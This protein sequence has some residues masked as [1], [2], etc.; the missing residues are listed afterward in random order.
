MILVNGEKFNA[1]E[2]HNGEV[3][4]K[5]PQKVNIDSNV[6]E[7]IFENNKDITA[8]MFAKEYLDD[9]V[10]GAQRKLIMKYCPYERMD[11]AINDQMF[12]MK[13]FARIIAKMG[14]DEVFILDPHS[15]VCVNELYK[16]GLNVR[17]INLEEYVNKVIDD[18]QPDYICYPDKGAYKKY[19]KVLK[20]IDIPCFYGQKTRDLENKGHITSYEL[21]DAPDLTDKKVLIVDDICCLGGTAYNAATE[22]KKAGAKEVAFYI[23]HCENGIF[24]GKILKPE[25]IYEHKEVN[26]D[27]YTVK[28]EKTGE[29]R[30]IELDIPVGSK[31]IIDKVYT[32][33]T[34]LL[35]NTHDNIIIVK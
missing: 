31:Y 11:R 15:E 21:V 4:F 32:A 7:M 12:S 35:N 6:I 28:G 30:K 2:F 23:S 8:L 1:E 24:A 19:P 29:T 9:V 14:F 18:F 34:M 27:T 33:D 25:T 10:L 16:A 3:I 13:Y 17:I 20:N 26:K 5:K 22:M